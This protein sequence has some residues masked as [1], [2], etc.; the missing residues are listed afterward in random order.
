MW[1]LS[2]EE[3][4]RLV[5]LQLEYNKRKM[6]ILDIIESQ[7]STEYIAEFGSSIPFRFLDASQ[8]KMYDDNGKELMCK[9]GKPATSQICGLEQSLSC[10]A[11]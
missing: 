8:V 4:K 11:I 5:E 9:C 6:A 7:K 10:P 3:S 1:G 2:E